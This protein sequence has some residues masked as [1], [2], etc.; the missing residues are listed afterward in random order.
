MFFKKLGML[1]VF[2]GS[3]SGAYYLGT[4]NY[5]DNV[6]FLQ[7][8]RNVVINLMQ[9]AKNCDEQQSQEI[10]QEPEQQEQ[11]QI[12]EPAA[13]PVSNNEVIEI[14]T[15]DALRDLIKEHKEP[16]II[17]F[18]MNGCGFC[19]KMEPIYHEIVKNPRFNA[20]KFY[21]VNGRDLQAPPIVQELVDQK[22]NGYP[23]FLFMNQAGYMDKHAGYKPQQDFEAKIASV[24]GDLVPADTNPKVVIQAVE[25]KK[26]DSA[27]PASKST[28]KN[29]ENKNSGKPQSQSSKKSS[30]S[31]QTSPQIKSLIEKFEQATNEIPGDCKSKKTSKDKGSSQADTTADKKPSDKSA[32]KKSNEAE[33]KEKKEK[34]EK[35]NKAYEAYK[36]LYDSA[37]EMGNKLIVSKEDN[38]K[39]K[40]SAIKLFDCKNI[41]NMVWRAW[42]NEGQEKSEP[43]AKSQVQQPAD[44][45][46]NEASGQNK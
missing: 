4:Q 17:F 24:F 26:S 33:E 31:Q 7:K 18:H 23:F 34:S 41:R 36:K 9:P 15:Q 29:N 14:T 32:D 3:L 43:K 6:E 27:Q 11:P 28:S 1:I 42:K 40:K 19:K 2:I 39:V 22:I 5:L 13:A 44:K 45:K 12:V 46:N 20:I 35:I 38:E 25:T 30:Q 16:A 21:S 8:M 37:K 10:A